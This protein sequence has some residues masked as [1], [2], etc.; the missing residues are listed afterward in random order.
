M[1]RLRQVADVRFKGI[2]EGTL[3]GPGVV[4][5]RGLHRLFR[6]RWAGREG[7]SGWG[8]ALLQTVVAVLIISGMGGDSYARRKQLEGYERFGPYTLGLLEDHRKVYADLRAFI[9]SHWLDHRKGHATLTTTSPAEFVT[10]TTDYYI[11]PDAKGR[12][13][14]NEKSKC[15]AGGGGWPRPTKERS[16]WYS[17]QRV[18]Q[19]REGKGGNEPIPDSAEVSADSYVLVL[20]GLSGR[21]RAQL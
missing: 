14:I 11:E 13:H 5:F 20:R 15:G 4:C 21:Q 7:M 18:S 12:W 3:S 19:G 9:W 1:E 6:S 8:P 17:V 2:A 10:C 16:I